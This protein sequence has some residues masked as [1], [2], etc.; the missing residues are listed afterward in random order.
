ML[1]KSAII[2]PCC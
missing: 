1:T 2:N